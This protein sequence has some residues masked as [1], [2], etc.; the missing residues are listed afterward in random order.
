MSKQLYYDVTFHLLFRRIL[1]LNTT[2]TFEHA[3]CV[4]LL[5]VLICPSEELSE[6]ITLHPLSTGTFTV[7]LS[8]PALPIPSLN[9]WGLVKCQLV[10]H[11]TFSSRARWHSWVWYPQGFAVSVEMQ[12]LWFIWACFFEKAQGLWK[13]DI[14]C[15]VFE[16][17]MVGAC[18]FHFWRSGPVCTSSN[19]QW[20]WAVFTYDERKT[21]ITKRLISGMR[22]P[23]HSIVF[24]A[25]QPPP[26]P[27]L[28]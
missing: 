27:P 17:N 8:Q 12:T 5:H 23:Q 19:W 7:S 1:R 25:P 20:K 13:T 16:S 6:L 9:P 22:D 2:L 26:S 28:P 14:L 18:F 4:Y 21:T 24:K 15:W 11:P 3:H 10:C